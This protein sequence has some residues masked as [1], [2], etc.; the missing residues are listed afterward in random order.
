LVTANELV[1]ER[2]DQSVRTNALHGS[3]AMFSTAP[4]LPDKIDGRPRGRVGHCLGKN[5]TCMAYV[6]VGTDLCYFH[7]PDADLPEPPPPSRRP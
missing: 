6:I 1:G 7:T 3:A 2:T 4:Y 5:D